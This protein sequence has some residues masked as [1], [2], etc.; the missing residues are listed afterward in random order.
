[1]FIKDG[2]VLTTFRNGTERSNLKHG[3]IGGRME[4]GETPRQGTIREIFEEVGLEIEPNN[5]KLAHTMSLR[6]PAFHSPKNEENGYGPQVSCIQHESEGVVGYYFL[7]QKWTGEPV[8]KEPH[9]H[10]RLEWLEL[11]SLPAT[12]IDRNV[13]ALHNIQKGVAYSEYGWPRQL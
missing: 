12:L 5:L 8:N 9:I 3:F 4:N 6:R 2:K 10:K 1:M 13:Q 7:V 11:S